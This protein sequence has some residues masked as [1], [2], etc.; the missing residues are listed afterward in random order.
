MHVEVK[1]FDLRF[2]YSPESFGVDTQELHEGI[3]GK[4][5]F[6]DHLHSAKQR[7]VIGGKL[8]PGSNETGGFDKALRDS[9]VH[10]YTVG[11]LL[12]RVRCAAFALLG[13]IVKIETKERLRSLVL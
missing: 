1:Q 5:G 4:A 8:P 2:G 13:Q 9:T 10:T 11:K 7:E 6:E 12:K 3:L